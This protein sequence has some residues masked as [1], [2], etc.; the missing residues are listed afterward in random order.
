MASVEP[1]DVDPVCYSLEVVTGSNQCSLQCSAGCC[2]FFVEELVHCHNR[3]RLLLAAHSN[4]HEK[5]NSVE[6]LL[7][8]I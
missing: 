1:L 2:K 8:N 6:I 4:H 7:L 5:N 3:S